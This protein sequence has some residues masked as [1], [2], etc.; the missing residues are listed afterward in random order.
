MGNEIGTLNAPSS[1]A[2]LSPNELPGSVACYRS[3]EVRDAF[4]CFKETPSVVS[5]YPNE[6]QVVS[7]RAD[8]DKSCYSMYK[9]DQQQMYICSDENRV[10][11]TLIYLITEHPH[12]GAG[13][14]ADAAYDPY[15]EDGPSRVLR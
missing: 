3:S 8:I 5:E 9:T 4:V 13:T 6:Y 1:R 7:R 10:N 11:D 14:S 15:E 12:P 2:V